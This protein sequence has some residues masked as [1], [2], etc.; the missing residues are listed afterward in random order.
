MF[1]GDPDFVPVGI[2]VEALI[3]EVAAKQAELPQMVS[4]V[5]AT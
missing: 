5:F 2:L 1:G 4:D 3:A